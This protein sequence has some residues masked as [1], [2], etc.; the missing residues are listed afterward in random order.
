MR[1]ADNRDRDTDLEGGFEPLRTLFAV[2]VLLLGFAAS[3]RADGG[4]ATFSATARDGRS[5]ELVALDSEVRYEVAGLVAEAA[6]RQRFRN[7]SDQWIEAQ[8]LLPLP[9]GAA[10]HDLE[11]RVG[12]RRIVGEIRE[13][14]AARAAYVEAA[15]SGRRAALIENDRAHLFRTAVANIAPGETIAVDVR[16]WQSV[17]YRD[18]RFRLELPLTYT[19][20]YRGP[21]DKA[22]DDAGD[23]HTASAPRVAITVELEA[24][25]ALARVESAS[26]RIAVAERSG[27]HTITL[28]DGV[29]P[30][31]R[32]FVLEWT[33]RLGATP[34]S[35]VLTEVAGNET[36]ALLMLL[37]RAELANPLPRELI[38]VID[39]SGSMEGASIHQARAAL[40]LALSQLTPADRFNV[41]QF[42]S[43]TEALFDQAVAATADDVKLAREWVA[44][45]VASGGTEMAPALARAFAGNAPAGYLRQ[46]VFATDGA[47]EN[48]AALYTLI[49]A[50]LGESRLFPVGIGSAPNAQFIHRAATLGRGTA[51]LIR[52]L[53][54]VGPAM[55]TLFD[56]LEKPAL[57]DL[58]LDWPAGT[59]TW[60][61]RLPDLYAGE[62][63]MV[64]ARLGAVGTNMQARGLMAGAPWQA[65]LPLVRAER[66]RG[67]VRLWAQRK[68]DTLEQSV[69]LGA[70]ADAM[71]KAIT[72]I[73]IEHRLVTRHTSLV[74][75]EQ[76]PV[77]T[78]DEDL[79]SHRIANGRPADGLGFATTATPA[80]RRLLLGLLCLL[81]AF[82]FTAHARR[83]PWS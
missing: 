35:A 75:I 61:A 47:I 69:E 46:V 42:N 55:R 53:D 64:V 66:S 3:A 4:F 2:I 17:D 19:P 60:P 36:Y 76:T 51:T 82:A 8:Y 20:R 41:I 40:D 30:A 9:D 7:D 58:A 5:F 54:E 11:L 32:D 39:T 49:D 29:V 10:V 57:R 24:G 43:R 79:V 67:I 63:L 1:T 59:E 34:A 78:L 14:E 72:A 26:H 81:L 18:E 15:A 77:R 52:G 65:S 37:P 83:Q 12:Q 71:R 21:S 74:A 16:W 50:Q 62:P 25:V 80:P 45:L 44:S 22:A 56:K 73:A 28:A 48:A 23:A 68:I 6:I 27:R 31:E 38:L 70:D 13:K 33:P